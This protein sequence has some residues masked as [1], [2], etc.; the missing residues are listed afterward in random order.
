[1]QYVEQKSALSEGKESLY[2]RSILFLLTH[3]LWFIIKSR[4]LDK[5]YNFYRNSERNIIPTLANRPS[6]MSQMNTSLNVPGE[7]KTPSGISKLPLINIESYD[8]SSVDKQPG[9]N[10]MSRADTKGSSSKKLAGIVGFK[11]ENKLSAGPSLVKNFTSTSFYSPTQSSSPHN[12]SIRQRI[13]NVKPITPTNLMSNNDDNLDF[14]HLAKNR[15]VIADFNSPAK[16]ISPL[17]QSAI[18][19]FYL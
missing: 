17:Y 6:T 19:I 8:D 15:I 16:G 12:Q 9:S 11:D 2:E 10:S 3:Q 5:S 13:G 4:D 18:S 7:S 14:S 1:M